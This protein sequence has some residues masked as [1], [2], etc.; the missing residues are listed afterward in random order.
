MRYKVWFD[1]ENHIARTQIIKS[2][3]GEEAR[4][5]MTEKEEQL[6]NNTR[7]G[8]MD[9][10]NADSIRKLSKETYRKHT[11]ELP[12]DK[13]AVIVD[14]SVMRMIAKIFI[15]GLGMSSKTRSVKLNYEALSRFQG[16]N[17]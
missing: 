7:T 5:L 12:L 9:L 15:A 8:I 1:K 6:I 17:E 14:S 4:G 16:G 2:L 13:A 11:N 3:T 10:S